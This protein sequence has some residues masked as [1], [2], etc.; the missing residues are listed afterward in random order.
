M[1]L[2]QQFFLGGV[3]GLG[4]SL[5]LLIALYLSPLRETAYYRIDPEISALRIRLAQYQ[6]WMAQTD[7]S[8]AQA[9]GEAT[10][11]DTL[12][13][14]QA[15][16]WKE[17]KRWRNQMGELARVHARPSAAAFWSWLFSLRYWALPLGL[18]LALTPALLLIARAL[19][20]RPKP[21]GGAARAQAL[22]S[23]QQAVKKVAGISEAGRKTEFLPPE[24]PQT[25][26]SRPE[27]RASSPKTDALSDDPGHTMPETVS[28]PLPIAEDTGRETRF[29]QVGP[30][31]GET[32]DSRNTELRPGSD[33][34]LSMEDED[35][36]AD[37]DA[38]EP[39]AGLGG[40][41]LPPTTEVE[42][43]ERKKAEVL[44]LARKGLTSSE[45]SRR[46]RISQD[47]VEFIIRLRREKG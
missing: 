2:I 43:V 42:R 8:I 22:S 33:Q 39:E 3:G 30:G 38:S 44:K 35:E 23:F 13:T 32:E 18:F 46:L 28:I 6:D 21:R 37:A 4:I 12:R 24:W 27:G 25:G 14:A 36:D 47:Q 11:P 26:G 9:G 20:S 15:R 40:S 7:L 5:A 34:G 41:F 19:A 29:F 16:A 10:A 1:K 31:W 45:I 17:Y